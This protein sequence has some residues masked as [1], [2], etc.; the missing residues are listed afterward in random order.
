MEA[1]FGST[2]LTKSGEKPTLEAL[3]GA[4]VVGLYF[5][6]SLFVI[7][8]TPYTLYSVILYTPYTLL[9]YTPMRTLL[10]CALVSAMPRVHAEAR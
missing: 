5:V 7:L 3:G 8:Y 6:S 2:L 1:L 9:L 10:V 4:E